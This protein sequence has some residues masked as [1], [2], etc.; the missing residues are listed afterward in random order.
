MYI[1]GH[2][3]C[4]LYWFYM[5]RRLDFGSLRTLPRYEARREIGGAE[6]FA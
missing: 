2:G 1:I 5:R 3:N 4:S 6:V